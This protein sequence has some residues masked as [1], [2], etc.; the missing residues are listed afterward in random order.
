VTKAGLI[1]GK[2]RLPRVVADL[3]FLSE[4]VATQQL[5]NKELGIQDA[6]LLKFNTAN[7]LT[8]PG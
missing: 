4:L 2:I 8:A 6:T 3:E 5:I 7:T 1:I